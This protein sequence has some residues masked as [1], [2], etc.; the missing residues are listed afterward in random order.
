MTRSTAR[1]IS[2]SLDPLPVGMTDML[3]PTSRMP[4]SFQATRSSSGSSGQLCRFPDGPSDH[5]TLIKVLSDRVAATL[6][7][8]RTLSS[9]LLLQATITSLFK[10]NLHA[11]CMKYCL[12]I[13]I[14]SPSL[15]SP[16][17]ISTFPVSVT[18]PEARP[19]RLL[20]LIFASKGILCFYI[21]S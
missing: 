19:L 13:R 11:F 20:F 15:S 2:I 14:L 9:S 17:S 12:R 5:A 21:L 10:Y 8:Y 3:L 16:R 7:L 18:P 1:E 4:F 6:Y